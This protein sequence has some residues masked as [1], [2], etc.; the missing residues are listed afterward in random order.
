MAKMLDSSPNWTQTKPTT[1]VST[2][3]LGFF[4]VEVNGV[5]TNPYVAD[6]LYSRAVRGIM[7]QGEVFAV[8]KPS[9]D[10]FIVVM[11][12]DTA[13]DGDYTE[14]FDLDDD[15]NQ[16]AQRLQA[17]V[18]A[19]AGTCDGVI[20]RHLEGSGFYN[21]RTYYENEADDDC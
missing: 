17:A 11:A 2:R 18:A 15:Y 13:N 19:S 12:H 7:T 8:G 1:R 16:Q 10:Y 21:G 9:G 20:T 6:S 4:Q 5:G 14:E 3:Q